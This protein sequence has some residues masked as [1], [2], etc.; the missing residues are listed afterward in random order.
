VRPP[1]KSRAQQPQP[2]SSKATRERRI[3]LRYR[4]AVVPPPR[5]AAGLPHGHPAV[6][7]IAA[8]ASNFCWNSRT[9]SPTRYNA[10][11]DVFVPGACGLTST[12]AIVRSAGCGSA[13][14]RQPTQRL[15]QALSETLAFLAAAQCCPS[16]RA[17]SGR[18]RSLRAHAT[19]EPDGIVQRH[20]WTRHQTALR[21]AQDPSAKRVLLTFGLPKATISQAQ[22]T[23]ASIRQQG[24]PHKP[25]CVP[26]GDLKVS[27]GCGLGSLFRAPSRTAAHPSRVAEIGMW[28]FV[29]CTRLGGES[30]LVDST[31]HRNRRSPIVAGRV[32]Q[33]RLLRRAEFMFLY[34]DCC[35][36]R[37]QSQPSSDPVCR[38]GAVAFR[39]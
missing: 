33:G 21:A 14:A 27:K 32:Q 25:A 23:R 16:A 4:K 9:V 29:G 20:H 3:G 7:D 11:P 35:R 39:R 24:P 31:G 15:T 22:K 13:L 18:R 17:A 5:C 34:L 8:P 37:S 36:C 1:P 10:S 6:A 30:S 26:D 28:R 38:G 19:P 12:A 2:G